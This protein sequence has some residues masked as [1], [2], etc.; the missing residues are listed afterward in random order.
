VSRHYAGW[1]NNIDPDPPI[2][3]HQLFQ[4]KILPFLQPDQP[5]VWVV[6]DNLRYDHWKA[7]EPLLAYHYSIQE[8]DCF[9]SILP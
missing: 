9:F 5:L 4:K 1:V 7:I 2:M 6:L 8:E 3:S